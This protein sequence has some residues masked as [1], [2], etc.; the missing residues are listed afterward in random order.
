MFHSGSG[1]LQRARTAK[2]V[3]NR[4]ETTPIA[5]TVAGNQSGPRKKY[6][7]RRQNRQPRATSARSPAIT[8]RPACPRP[9]RQ[10]QPSQPARPAYTTC[11][12]FLRPE[13]RR[14]V[15][16]RRAPFP[17][18]R[19]LL[20]SLHRSHAPR[21]APRRA[22]LRAALPCAGPLQPSGAPQSAPSGASPSVSLAGMHVPA[23]WSVPCSR[24]ARSTCTPP[25]RNRRRAFPPVGRAHPVAA[26]AASSA[27]AARGAATRSAPCALSCSSARSLSRSLPC[28]SDCTT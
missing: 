4:M 2:A 10:G 19:S 11:I 24:T 6:R 22:P 20:A 3:A 27:G 7:T 23:K 16:R 8:E 25:G 26:R 5:S 18:S 13:M 1:Q 28:A 15:R 21:S 9:S 14:P 17:G 12:R